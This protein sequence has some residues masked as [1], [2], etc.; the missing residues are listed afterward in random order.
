[1][2]KV[3]CLTKLDGRNYGMR[4]RVPDDLRQPIA[5]PEKVPEPLRAVLGRREVWKSC[6]AVPHSEARRLH[7]REMACLDALFAEARR[8]LAAQNGNDPLP[9]VARLPTPAEEDIRAAVRQWLRPEER[10]RLAEVGDVPNPETVVDNLNTDEAHLADEDGNGLRPIACPA[11]CVASA[12]ATLPWPCNALPC[13]LCSV[14]YA[15]GDDGGGAASATGS[16]GVW[17]SRCMT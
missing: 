14:S 15:A 17:A 5:N 13:L 3:P 9:P 8:W 6:G 16:K 12:L 7:N 2:P 10:K 11:S 4:R 1:V